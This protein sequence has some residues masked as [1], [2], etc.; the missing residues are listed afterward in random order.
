MKKELRTRCS[1]FIAPLT[2][3][4]GG[5]GF[6]ASDFSGSWEDQCVDVNSR[7]DISSPQRLVMQ[8][9]EEGRL[10]G[11]ISWWDEE[12]LDSSGNPVNEHI[13]TIYGLADVSDGTF[14]LVEEPE[15]GTLVGRIVSGG[16]VELL[17]T[18]PGIHP[19]V[20]ASTLESIAD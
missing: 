20:T 18:Q 19:V 6:H 2:L 4:M 5:C 13:E 16:R 15:N 14:V 3:F 7:G 9:D 12:G 8:A 1:W 17:R 11:T 10:R